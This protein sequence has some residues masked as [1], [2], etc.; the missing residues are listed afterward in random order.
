MLLDS[1][2]L[3]CTGTAPEKKNDDENS[4]LVWLMHYSSCESHDDDDDDDD[5]LSLAGKMRCK[6]VRSATYAHM[7]VLD[8]FLR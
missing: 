4:G 3:G 7:V 8:M 2:I 6:R 1:R 5:M